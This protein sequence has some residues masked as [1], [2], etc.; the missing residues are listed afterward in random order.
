MSW[1]FFVQHRP[2]HGG[3]FSFAQ[4]NGE[5]RIEALQKRNKGA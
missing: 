3:A 2:R 1:L 4:N 5:G